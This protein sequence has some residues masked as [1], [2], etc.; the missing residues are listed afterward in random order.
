[1]DMTESLAAPLEEIEAEVESAPSTPR[2]VKAFGVVLVVLL[3]A[4]LV[5]HL[6]GHAPMAGMHGS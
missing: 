4:F 6:T 5:L 3:L 1:M 2:W